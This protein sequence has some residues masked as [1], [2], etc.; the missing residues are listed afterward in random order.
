MA[1]RAGPAIRRASQAARNAMQ[2]LDADTGAELQALYAAAAEQLRATILAAGFASGTG[3]VELDQLRTLLAA[4][5][6]VLDALASQRT[7]LVQAAI[8]RAADLGVQPFTAAGLA[9]T[10][11]SVAE[12]L[13]AGDAVA[14]SDAAVSFV[15]TFRHEDGLVL[16]DRLWRVDAGAKEVLHRAIETAVV[17]GWS[18][19]K[20]A[21]EL[22]YR[23]DSVPAGTRKAQAAAE[24]R[25]V[26]GA[27]DVL[28]D[29]SAGP[30][31]STL[32]VMRTEINRAHGE[33]Y[34]VG[35]ER[36]P[37]VVGFRFLLS[38]RHPRPDI[39]DLLARQNLHGLGPGVYPTREKT[40][41]PAHPNTL[42]FIVAVFAEEVTD[43]HRAGKETSLEAL[44]RLAPE[45]RAGL[46]GPTKAT[47]FDRGLLR[48]GTIRSR[49]RDVTQRLTRQGAL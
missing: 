38:P 18:A 49:V 13:S 12:V 1:D 16:S 40:P 23:G 19:D 41:W 25:A 45:L 39:C 11:R 33:A 43:E 9:A 36:A 28:R 6:A 46:L 34:M 30:L 32:R 7:A 2:Q 20:A 26:A 44:G 5:D 14:A 27:A 48:T 21:A 3:Q 24:A 37:G 29:T 8:E 22:L 4:V 35:A 47:Y 17:Q 10:G 42:S 31:A 15:R